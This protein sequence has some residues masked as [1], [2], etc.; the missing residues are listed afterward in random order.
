ML[1]KDLG[2]MGNYRYKLLIYVFHKRYPIH[3]SQRFIERMENYKVCFFQ[4]SV[5]IY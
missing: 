4:Y 5:L 2:L 1:V 3:E